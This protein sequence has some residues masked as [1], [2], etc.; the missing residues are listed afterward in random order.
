MGTKELRLPDAAAWNARYETGHTPWDLGRAPPALLR[1]LGEIGPARL[2]V[3]VP[4]A[5][6]GHDAF[7]WAEAGHDVTALDFAPLAVAALGAG[8]AERGLR[9]RAL[10]ADVLAPPPDLLGAF[11]AVWEQTCLCAIP[12]SRWPDYVRA[13][14][15]TL[16]PG[17]MLFALL[18]SHGMAGG[19]PWDVREDDVRRLFP[20][21]FEI[22]RIDPVPDSLRGREILARLR[23]S[24]ST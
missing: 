5:G 20:P 21:A 8:A 4:G 19:P 3:L 15:G 9:V 16:V 2:R 14:A 10:E 23:R 1:L 7:A 11:D 12:P 18:W 22:E 13:I 17:G 24:R 6:R